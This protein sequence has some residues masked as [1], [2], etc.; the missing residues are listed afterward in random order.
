MSE[1][2]T[3]LQ[4]KNLHTYFFT[5]HGVVPSVNGVTFSIK[6]G[7]TVGIVGESGC[8]KS[9]TSLSLLQLVDEPGKIIEGEILFEGQDLTKFN[10]KQLRKVRGNKISMVFQEPLTSLN[11]VF[12]IG[13]QIAEAIRLHQNVNK[14]EAK[15]KTIEMLKRVGI[16]RAERHYYSFPHMLS[17]GMRQRVMI[18]MALSCHPQLLIADEPTTALDVTIQAQ[19]LNLMKELSRE[20]DTSIILITHDLGVVAEMVDR[21]IVMYAGQ[22]VEQN[23]VFEIF[24]NP[25]HPYTKG[26]LNS[27]PKIHHLKDQLESIE[28][29]VPSPFEMPTG[30]KFHPRCPFSTEK[31]LSQE[32]PLFQIEGG[33]EVRCWLHEEHEV[34]KG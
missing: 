27:T 8:G 21:V 19:I 9:V 13:S 4:V 25:K 3:L 2:E 18:A 29:N 10:K 33:S 23:S 7:E 22:I 17:G 14:E 30:C 1:T 31:C 28:G 26:L 12:T 6:K 32:P 16:P 24:K 11:P 5:E 34:T 20:Y 15:I